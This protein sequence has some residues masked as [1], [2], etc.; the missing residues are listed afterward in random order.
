MILTKV[1]HHLFI[2]VILVMVFLVKMKAFEYLKFAS[3][4][5]DIGATLSSLIQPTCI[6]SS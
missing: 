4:F 3:T 2:I 5:G 1:W 6:G